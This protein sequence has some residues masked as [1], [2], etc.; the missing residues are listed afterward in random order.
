M[1]TPASR[2][3]SARKKGP[4]CSPRKSNTDSTRRVEFTDICISIF[5]WPSRG[6]VIILNDATHVDFAFLGLSTTNPPPKKRPSS[7]TR[8][9]ASQDGGEESRSRSASA[10][11]VVVA[12][13]MDEASQPVEEERKEQQQQE[14]H[15]SENEEEDTLCQRLL[16]LGAKLWDS[17]KR[18]QFVDHFAAGIQP[19]VEDVE[20][21]RVAEPTL[22]ERRWVKVG[23][24]NN[25][26][27]GGGGCGGNG[28]FWILDCDTNWP[29]IIE[30]D[31]LVP[32]DA[33]RVKLAKTMEERCEILKGLG[34][35]FYDGLED[36]ESESTF[37]KAWDW[38]WE[39]EI[40]AL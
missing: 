28:G 22:R 23:W 11:V 13:G 21:G 2:V 37:L 31:N 39:G 40:G 10:G 36:Y 34:A 12:D 15:A 14:H 25:V 27:G 29:G 32:A 16:I 3:S 19:F 30:E 7:S 17:E 26:T 4:S 24:E 5:G 35:M 33:A 20:E 18:Y 1:R 9:T 8:T 38:K 6:G